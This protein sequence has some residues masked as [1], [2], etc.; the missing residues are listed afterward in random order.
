MEAPPPNPRPEISP[1]DSIQNHYPERCWGCG[2]RL[3][4]EDLARHRTQIVEIPPVRVQVSEHRFHCLE[5]EQ[6]GGLTRGW[7]EAILNGSGY[8]ERVAAHVAVLSG[9]YR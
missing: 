1:C 3:T 7:D 6:C 5:C 9:Q 8:G 2:E 4:G